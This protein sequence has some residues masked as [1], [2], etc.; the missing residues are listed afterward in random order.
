MINFGDKSIEYDPNFKFFLTT[1]IHNPH[2]LPETCIKLTVI[3]FS[4][5]F[6]GLTDQ[7]LVDVIKNEAPEI[8][9]QRDSLVIRLASSKNALYKLQSQILTE[10]AESNA[11]TILDNLTLIKTLEVCNSESILI[12]ESVAEAE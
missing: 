3:N 10:L 6:E 2:F 1:K 11:D 5:T 4:I 12:A 7:M 9:E 8:E